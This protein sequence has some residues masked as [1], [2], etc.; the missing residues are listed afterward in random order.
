MSLLPAVTFMVLAAA[1]WIV[2]PVAGLRPSRG[3][4]GTLFEGEEA[5]QAQFVLAVGYRV[6]HDVL[7]G[8]EHLVG[9]GLGDPGFA[10]HS[11][12]EVN[13]SSSSGLW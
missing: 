11:G 5:L 13:R 9:V 6:E 1:I 12:D 8:C 3:G 7:E 4:A 10:S 2:S